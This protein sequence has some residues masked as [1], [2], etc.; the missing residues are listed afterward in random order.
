MRNIN[1]I[2]KELKRHPDFV[3]AEIF[4]TDD[5][6]TFDMFDGCDEDETEGVEYKDDNSVIITDDMKKQGKRLYKK[7]CIDFFQY[8]YQY[9]NPGAFTFKIKNGKVKINN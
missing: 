9:S 6:E 2:I 4:T 8:A 1:E 5:F 7:S 3:Y